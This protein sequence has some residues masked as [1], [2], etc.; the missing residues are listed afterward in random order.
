M[1]RRVAPEC[2]D[3]TAEGHRAPE[4][5]GRRAHPVLRL[6]AAL[7]ERAVHRIGSAEIDAK[8]DECRRYSGGAVDVQRDSRMCGSKL[9]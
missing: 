9:N 8:P 4:T 1:K 5:A 2:R 6:E 7:D 3:R